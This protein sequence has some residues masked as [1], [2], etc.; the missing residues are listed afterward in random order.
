MRCSAGGA[1]EG[2]LF[3]VG[4]VH[5]PEPGPYTQ[6]AMLQEAW[7][8]QFGDYPGRVFGAGPCVGMTLGLEIEVGERLV[9]FGGSKARI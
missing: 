8:A 3:L 5:L 1:L 6:G 9:F 2:V 7:P 4:E